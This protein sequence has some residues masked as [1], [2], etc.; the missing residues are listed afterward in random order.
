MS[1][2]GLGTAQYGL[3]Y[4]ISSINGQVGFDE[5]E[6]II[7]F[8]KKHEI[9]LLDTAPAYGSSE[10]VLGSANTTNFDIVT[11]TRYF[12][13]NVIGDKEVNQMYSDLIQSISLLKRDSVYGLLLHNA[14][15]LLK[16]GAEKII[17]KL[18]DLKTQ[19]LVKKIGTSV[20]N[21][22]QLKKI[23]DRFDIDLV[24]VPFNIIDRRFI[25][26]DVLAKLHDLGIEIHARSVFLQGLLLMRQQ[27]IPK[28]FRR[29]NNLWKDWFQWLRDSNLT[30]LEA[31]IRYAVSAPEITKVLVGVESKNQLKSIIS[32]L[33]GTIPVIPEGLLMHDADLLNPSNWN[34][35]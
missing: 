16:P 3:N 21:P 7:K 9:D 17:H 29:W 20:Y 24:Q 14:D 18:N 19:G 25:E 12:D 32:A 26:C 22:D 34:K 27:N 8:A 31:S 15:D 33:D 1:K 30:P 6:R 5:V 35:L 13:Q 11:K 23:T 4:G 28:K 2:L 10:K